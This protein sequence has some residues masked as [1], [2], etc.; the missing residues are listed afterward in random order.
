MLAPGQMGRRQYGQAVGAFFV[1]VMT[2]LVV[3]TWGTLNLDTPWQFQKSTNG[4]AKPATFADVPIFLDMPNDL[5]FKQVAQQTHQVAQQTADAT[6]AAKQMAEAKTLELLVPKTDSF[7][8]N[9]N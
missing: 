4:I 3:A 8:P 9:F 5:G 6:L 1:S 2:M 7:D